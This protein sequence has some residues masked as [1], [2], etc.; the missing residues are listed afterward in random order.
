MNVP[1]VPLSSFG[2]LAGSALAEDL[3]RLVANP[4]YAALV[5]FSDALGDQLA[6]LPIGQGETYARLEDVGGAEIEGLRPLCALRLRGA[7]TDAETKA[8]ARERELAR[9][10]E[11][12]KVRER[13][14]VEC[15][16][17]MAELGQS[18]SEREAML[19]QREQ[20]LI[21]KER[22]FFRRSGEAT[23]HLAKG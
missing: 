7:A 17:K 4:A 15:E 6:I 10:E 21:E 5:L 23:R 1:V 19:E 16:R 9:I 11:S 8:D 22:E 12:L 20:M 3:R 2:N 18:L 14:V 13:F